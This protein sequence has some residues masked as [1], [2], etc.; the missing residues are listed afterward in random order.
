MKNLVGKDIVKKVPFMGEEVEIRKLSAGRVMEVQELV[1]DNSKKDAD[2]M[3]LV[4][5]VI[6]LAAPSA[7]ELSDAD[8][9]TFPLEDMNT[10]V[11]SIMTFSGLGTGAEDEGN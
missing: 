8:F 3:D 6:K 7:S 11:E 9:L 10:L 5:G 1:K 4:R 2:P